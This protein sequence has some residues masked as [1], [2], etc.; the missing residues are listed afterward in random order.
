M[1]LHE[2]VRHQGFPGCAPLWWLSQGELQLIS[3]SGFLTHCERLPTSK[4]QSQSIIS[5][6]YVCPRVVARIYTL[7]K[8]VSCFNHRVAGAEA[9]VKK[10]RGLIK[11]MSLECTAGAVVRRRAINSRTYAFIPYHAVRM[12]Q[13]RRGHR[14]WP[15]FELKSGAAMAAPAAPMP[16][17]LQWLPQLQTS[18]RDHGYERFA[19]VLLETNCIRQPNRQL[20]N[21][22]TLTTLRTSMKESLQLHF[23]VAVRKL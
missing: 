9:A 1:K 11:F 2:R 10:W 17:P 14:A 19:L 21:Y 22:N 15:M 4:S 6:A 5:R 7:K 18:W 3:V 8:Q 23:K 13:L 16:P 12:L 20:P